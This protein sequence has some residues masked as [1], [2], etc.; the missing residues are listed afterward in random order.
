MN[1]YQV[2]VS[3]VGT[4]FDGNS[5]PHA[6]ASYE[7][8]KADSINVIGKAAGEDVTLMYKGEPMTEYQG[9]LSQGR[10]EEEPQ[11][12]PVCNCL[13]CVL[14]RGIEAKREAALKAARVPRAG[15]YPTHPQAYTVFS[16]AEEAYAYA[17]GYLRAWVEANTSLAYEG[18]DITHDETSSYV[19]CEQCEGGFSLTLENNELRLYKL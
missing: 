17:A 13:T 8:Y 14:R 16:N 12:Q 18:V 9:V 15:Q 11:A 6:Q 1:Q 4:V 19:T 7:Q 10:E 3:N 2:I 5:Q